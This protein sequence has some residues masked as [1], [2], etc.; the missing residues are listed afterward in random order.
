MPSVPMRAEGEKKLPDKYSPL[1]YM[2]KIELTSASCAL[3]LPRGEKNN[4][5]IKAY[6]ADYKYIYSC[7]QFK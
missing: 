2:V 5:S 4:L 1:L 3:C 6:P 7:I